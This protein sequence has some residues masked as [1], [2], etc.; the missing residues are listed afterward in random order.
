MIGWIKLHRSL[1][2][3]EWYD[4]HN[5]TRLLVHLLISVNYEDK[6]WK[7]QVIKAG[8]MVLSW[9]TLAAS[10]HLSA[11]QVRTAMAKLESS[12]EV[13][14]QAT[15]RYQLVNLVKWENLQSKE[16]L[17]NRPDNR[18]ITGKQ[19]TDNR[20]ITTTKEGK[21]SKEP[22]EEKKETA[23]AFNFFSFLSQELNCDKQLLKDWLKVRAKKQA[24]NTETAAKLFITQVKKSKLTA[25]EI[26]TECVERNWI[27]FNEEWLNKTAQ[28]TTKRT[29]KDVFLETFHNP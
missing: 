8:S 20:Q 13:T 26:L 2:N 25:D 22:K 19:Q 12:G 16:A 15:N 23:K 18:Q 9:D 29:G 17:D 11:Q 28:G 1:I 10:V 4:D 21:E 5:A 14:R 3:W 7:G 24:A 6:K 27:R